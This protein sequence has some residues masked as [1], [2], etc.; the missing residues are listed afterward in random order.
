MVSKQKISIRLIKKPV[1]KEVVQQ[2]TDSWNEIIER[3]AGNPW[4]KKTD[5]KTKEE[6]IIK[7]IKKKSLFLYILFNDKKPI[8]EIS[9][10]YQ[11][12]EVW[13]GGWL[14]PDSFG[15][16]YMDKAL[17]QV[18]NL[19]RKKGYKKALFATRSSNKRSVHLLERMGAKLVKQKTITRLG[20]KWV[21]NIYRIDL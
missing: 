3:K 10:S 20:K 6:E 12:R 9:G 16:G 4:W 2:L 1:A 15:K 17:K 14:D 8:G 7:Y 5:Y 19:I 13:L 21:N 18:L 11:D